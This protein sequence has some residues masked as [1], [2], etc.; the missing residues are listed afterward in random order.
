ML[1]YRR[2]GNRL[3]K[4]R[5]LFRGA[6][7]NY[8]LAL[9]HDVINSNFISDEKRELEELKKSLQIREDWINSTKPCRTCITTG[10]VRD[11]YDRSVICPDCDG[12]GRDKFW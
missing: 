4:S 2:H 6:H 10:Y 9:G 1:E 7:E 5:G 3:R 8:G 12:K 11:I